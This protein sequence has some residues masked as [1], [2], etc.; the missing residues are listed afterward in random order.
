MGTRIG[1]ER[2]AAW[3]VVLT[4]GVMMA[5]SVGCAAAPADAG[6]SG[7]P[8][9][10]ARMGG[11]ATARSSATTPEL[12]A[13]SMI[14]DHRHTDLSGVPLQWIDAAKSDLHIAYGHTSHGSQIITGMTGLI[15]FASAPHGGSTYAW[16]EG[17]T[18]GAL[19]IDDQFA[20]WL[21]LG[22]SDFA[23]WETATRSYLE[24]PANADV[25]VVMW[26]WCGGVSSASEANITTYLTLMS[27]LE[28]DYPEVS[29]VYMTGHTDGS[30]LTGNL[31]VRNQQIRDYC[32]VNDKIL[33]D[34]EDIESYD[35]D[36]TYF[37]DK[38]VTD[39]CWYDD[40]NWATEWQDSHTQGV[41]WYQ[42]ESA[43][44]EPLN[45]NLKAYAAWWLWAR[46]AGW[47]RSVLIKPTLTLRVSGLYQRRTEARRAIHG[48][49]DGHAGCPR[50]ERRSPS[51]CSATGSASGARS[52][53]RRRRSAPAVRMCGATD[54]P[55]EGLTA[56]RQR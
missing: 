54:L 44:S 19:D 36:G 46:L 41:D 25:N 10:G 8:S 22:S 53:A 30:G 18:G 9:P 42:C 14:I 16:N 43:H 29:F 45:A 7:S 55:R 12:A 52:S 27:R 32:E 50:R 15:T 26:S 6:S 40:G 2:R 1:R 20:G 37:G 48:Q 49:G 39:S 21:D 34:F 33:Y 3:A 4:V 47:E 38:N 23:G 31:H 5:L 13:D 17:G 35:P 24:D 11:D 28:E 56:Y 51:L